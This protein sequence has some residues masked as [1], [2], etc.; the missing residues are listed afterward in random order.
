MLALGAA[1]SFTG[2]V[3]YVSQADRLARRLEAQADVSL[4]QGPAPSAYTDPKPV[5]DILAIDPVVRAMRAEQQAIAL[6]G[7]ADVKV[8]VPK[9]LAFLH[10]M[11]AE[12]AVRTLT[13]LQLEPIPA[14]QPHGLEFLRRGLKGRPRRAP[15]GPPSPVVSSAIHR[16]ASVTGVSKAY[17]HRTAWRESSF[18]PY[19]RAPTSS[20]TGLFQFVERTWLTMVRD[21][22]PRYGLRREAALVRQ[23]A[24]GRPY[25]PDPVA[26]AH[27]LG[28][29]YDP[30]VSALLAAELAR[31]NTRA[32]RSSLGREPRAS[33]LY[34]AHVLGAD[35]AAEI[36]R[37]ERLSP[38]RP[39][40]AVL[41]RAAKANR[42]LFFAN[43]RPR[44]TAAVV[45]SLSEGMSGLDGQP[46][47]SAA[48]TGQL[49]REKPIPR[50]ADP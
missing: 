40:A 17:L 12:K 49:W 18:D 15:P 25:I 36:L 3:L 8:T 48:L 46:Y 39:A 13:V 2:A 7:G 27:V 30:Q 5:L 35:G 50:A 47:P 21:Y 23:D 42:A 38:L 16:A 9:E 10:P 11:L 28:L 29:R 20:A 6:H 24:S 22:G 1:A 31:A 37:A 43:G 44:S 4:A 26:R 33:E 32:L 34:L 45:R 19:A 14:Q 41:P